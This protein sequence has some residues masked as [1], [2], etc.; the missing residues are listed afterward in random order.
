[1][2]FSL[3]DITLPVSIFF[4]VYGIFLVFYLI[5]GFFNLMHLLEYGRVGLPL[6]AIVIGFLGG[7]L[8]LIAG[9]IFW[10]FH[11]DLTY[12]ITLPEI[13]TLFKQT[14]LHTGGF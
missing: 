10:F 11:Y 2:P 9:S 7:S 12:S 14:F 6:F 13:I 5:Y 8:L 1:M 3:A 4:G